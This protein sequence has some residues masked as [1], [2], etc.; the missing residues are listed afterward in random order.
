MDDEQEPASV[1]P[2]GPNVEESFAAKLLRAGDHVAN[3]QEA[4]EE[5][6][7]EEAAT[8]AGGGAA[9]GGRGGQPLRKS[10]GSDGRTQI[11]S[12]VQGAEL[13]LKPPGVL[14]WYSLAVFDMDGLGCAIEAPA[15]SPPLP[16]PSLAQLPLLH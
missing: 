13:A 15:V 9:A 8:A 11:R 4:E 1:Y 6:D 5:D 14:P 2:G 16:G 10:M 12:L 3:K 7:E